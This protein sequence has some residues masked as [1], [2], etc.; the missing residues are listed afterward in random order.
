[1]T[2]GLRTTTST[3]AGRIP[4]RAQLAVTCPTIMNSHGEPAAHAT[5]SYVILFDGTCHLCNG[6]V[7]FIIRRDP[8]ALFSFAS[9]QSDAARALL[10]DRHIATRSSDG[11]STIVVLRDGYLWTH[12]DAVLR[13]FAQLGMPWT[14]LWALFVIIPRPIRDSCYAFVAR[15]RYRWFGECDSCR[16][17]TEYEASRFL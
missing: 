2:Q 11:I 5:R 14:L 9:L 1:M 6:F 17:P 16:L 3:P 8:G 12:S 10:G 4:K 7:A 13:V 15:R